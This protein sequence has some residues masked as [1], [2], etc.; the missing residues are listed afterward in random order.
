MGGL[1]QIFNLL[2]RDTV[3]S[4]FQL[5]IRNQGRKR[6]ITAP[7]SKPEISP[8]N[9]VGSRL[10]CRNGVCHRAPDIVMAVNPKRR[11]TA[12]SSRGLQG[13]GCPLPFLA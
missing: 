13:T 5:Q 7:F 4:E 11:L 8:L 9:L 2:I 6:G 3:I 12:N 1:G 10:H